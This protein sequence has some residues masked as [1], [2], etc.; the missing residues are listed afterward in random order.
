M[1]DL[2][3][4]LPACRKDA[5]LMRKN[6]EWQ[7]E[8]GGCRPFKA[9]CAFDNTV[10]DNLTA[11][12]L[13]LAR[14]CYSFVW[15]FDYPKPRTE[16][17][18]YGPNHAFQHTALYMR[19]LGCPW[20]WF[21][22]DVI[23][24][25]AGWLQALSDEYAKS[26][27]KFMGSLIP[28]QGHCNGAA[29]YPAEASQI[30]PKAMLASSVAWD[31]VMK[32]EMIDYC[33]DASRLMQHAWG[34]VNGRFHPATGD[35]PSF[36]MPSD[37]NEIHPDAVVL[38][39]CKDGTL[40]DR[41]RETTPKKSP[42]VEAERSTGIFIR[43]YRNDA[44]WLTWAMKS[45]RRFAKDYDGVTLVFPQEDRDV[46]EKAVIGFRCHMIMTDND[47]GKGY[48]GQQVSKLSA[49][50]YIESDYILFFD[51][52]C[53]MLKP[54]APADWFSGGKIVHLITPWDHVGDAR[55]W[56]APT[57]K[58]LGFEARYE[59]MRRLPLL[60]PRWIV[61]HCREHIERVH[62]KPIR[63]YI[64]EQPAFSEFNALGTY[65]MVMEPQQFKFLDTTQNPLPDMIAIQR[66]SYGGLTDDIKKQMEEA[67]K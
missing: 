60:F 6:L 2:I 24:L 33:H 5:A 12:I 8:L 62:A 26:R 29:I 39:R 13:Q 50:K 27:K 48:L 57:E 17:W 14:E 51:S 58:A 11:P 43:T 36:L 10:P 20:F 32:P 18:P 31:V 4:V 37:M 34:R 21:E 1:T 67:L 23:P 38:H 63:Q 45:I 61:R 9:V 49:D 7:L 22:P 47:G 44:Q 46:I 55:M 15:R 65:A 25:R 40:I 56:K 42:Q 35:A 66:W 30:M 19:R 59:T 28:G 52:D 54:N 64:L 41:L 3:V 16:Y 53:F